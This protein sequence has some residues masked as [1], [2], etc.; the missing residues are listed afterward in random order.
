MRLYADENIDRLLVELLRERGHT[1]ISA[2]ERGPGLEDDAVLTASFQSDAVLLTEDKG[3]GE[4][5]TLRG[6]PCKGVVLLRLD[7]MPRRDA[8]AAAAGAI[9][10]L[11]ERLEGRVTVVQPDVIRARAVTA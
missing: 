5:V 11:R 2:A 3:F 6:K 9:E 7:V 1:V 4:L 8:I 10:L